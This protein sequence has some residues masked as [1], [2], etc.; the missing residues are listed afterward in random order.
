MPRLCLQKL[1]TQEGKQPFA[2][3]RP[4]ACPYFNNSIFSV[5]TNFPA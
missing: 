4:E 2:Q 1:R 3:G 5:R